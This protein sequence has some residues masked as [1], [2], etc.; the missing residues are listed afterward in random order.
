[1]IISPYKKPPVT[2][3]PEHPRLMLRRKDLERISNADRNSTAWRQYRE[4]CD[5][6]ILGI[7]A[8]PEKGTYHLKDYLAQILVQE[9]TISIACMNILL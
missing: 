7:G 3:P 4:L 1:M 9:V 8:I 6:P 2:P 5:F